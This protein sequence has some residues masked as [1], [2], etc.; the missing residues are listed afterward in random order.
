MIQIAR[1][2]LG[3]NTRRPSS[4]RPFNQRLPLAVRVWSN[5][6]PPRQEEL[7]R[8]PILAR[9]EACLFLADEPLTAKKLCELTGLRS[10]NAIREQI[11]QLNTFYHLDECAFRII[12]L[13]GGYQLLTQ[14]YYYPWVIR[15][16]PETDRL[17]LSVAALET[18]AVIAYKQ[19]IT[20]A[21]LEAIR[22]V[23]CSEPIRFLMEKGLIRIAGRHPSLG[24]PQLYAT[25]K[26]FLQFFGLNSLEDL[27]PTE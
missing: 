8:D 12:E 7:E 23:A 27:P 6:P 15:F 5:Q 25:T 18:L 3:P 2:L 14:P 11:N 17:G 1:P 24:R 13:A 26:R 19:P 21:D 16:R 20:R 9:L 4:Q 22:G 10:V